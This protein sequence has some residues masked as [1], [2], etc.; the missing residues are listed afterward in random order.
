MK[1]SVIIPT[2]N[3]SSELSLVLNA[4][5]MQSFDNF[6]V[7]I[8]DD[9]SIDSIRNKELIQ[10]RKYNISYI[11]QP[12]GGPASA[13]NMGLK[14]ITDSC[15]IILFIGDD[16][17]PHVDLLQQHHSFHQRYTD[18]HCAILGLTL[19]EESV[20]DEFMDFLAPYGPQFN[21]SGKSCGD[22]CDFRYLHT[23]NVSFKREILSDF[24]FDE[25]FKVAAFEDTEFGYRLQKERGLKII[26]N[27]SAIG[28][29]KHKYSREQFI[30][31][32]KKTA[33][34]ARL[35]ISKHPEVKNMI[36]KKWNKNLLYFL[37]FIC[38]WPIHAVRPIMPKKI[39]CLVY[40][41]YNLA[42]FE[43]L[44]GWNYITAK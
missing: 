20:R 40:K 13:R 44:F 1:I 34:W 28:Y 29:H 8:I 23:C 2:H 9:G 25:S 32:Q 5:G 31:R 6:D 14:N 36:I 12:S 41:Y 26:Y 35:M 4:L 42:F 33:P 19:W 21:Y 24:Y 7:I 30:E 27:P 43:I 22:I 16:I 18:S 39:G 3:R 11:Y 17:I 37:V 10:N 15:E 38:G